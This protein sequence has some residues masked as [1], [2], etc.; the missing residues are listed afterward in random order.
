VSEDPHRRERK[1]SDEKI[2]TLVPHPNM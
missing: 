1:F 2:F